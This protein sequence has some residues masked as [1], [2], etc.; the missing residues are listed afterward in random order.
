[1]RQWYV[2][3][4]LTLLEYGVFVHVHTLQQRSLIAST[5]TSRDGRKAL[6]RNAFRHAGDAAY[7]CWHDFTTAPQALA[8]CIAQRAA[9][10][11]SLRM[12]STKERCHFRQRPVAIPC[13]ICSQGM[14]GPPACCR[15][16]G[17]QPGSTTCLRLALST[18]ICLSRPT[19]PAFTKPCS[20]R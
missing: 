1:M 10:W 13:Q 18:A 9:P 16:S 6:L 14:P 12:P 20:C 7:A 17:T 11:Q 2:G 5:K 8:L 4:W 15:S 3:L 19:D